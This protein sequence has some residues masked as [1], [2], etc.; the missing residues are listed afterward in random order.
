MRH[1]CEKREKGFT[2]IELIISITIAV[3]IMAILAP[4]LQKMMTRNRLNGAGR[5]IVNDLMSSRMKASSQNNRFRVIFLDNHR[6]MIHDDDN[7]DNIVDTGETNVTKDIQDS[8]HDVTFSATAN[9]IFYPR[10]TS[11]GTTVTV[12]NSVGSR[13]VSVS[14]AGRVKID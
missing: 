10:G 12:S 6:Y 2:L 11:W 1:F 5:Q 3:I 4:E 14:T 13:A 8:Y 9:P 7:N